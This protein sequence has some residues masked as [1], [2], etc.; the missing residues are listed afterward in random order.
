[1]V[2]FAVL[3][4][5]RWSGSGG[6]IFH[7]IVGTAFTV[8]IFIHLYLNRKWIS[9]VAKKI[10]AKTAND[11]NKQLFAVD[12]VLAVAWGTAIFT[13]F[14]AIPSYLYGTDTFYVFGRL[15]GVSSRIGAA[16]ILVHIYQH[17]GQIRSYM[18][19]KK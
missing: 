18:K 17:R 12:A 19:L 15:H 16:V 14:L 5:V 6:F 3:S 11:K 13:G 7:A 4:F 1:M 10:A 8:L 2:I 9:T